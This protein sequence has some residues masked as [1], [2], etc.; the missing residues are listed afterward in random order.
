[1]EQKRITP[2]SPRAALEPEHVPIPKRPSRR[3]RHPLVIIGNAVITLLLLV[4]IVLGGAFALGKQRFEAS[5]P[6][7]QDKIV[8]IPR[9]LGTRDIADL[10]QRE[11]VIDQPW[12]FIG[13]VGLL[14]AR[15][16]E[17]KAGEY[18]FARQASLR[19]VVDTIIEGKV[20]QHL[21]T[22]PE[23]LTSE[24]IVQRLLEV[25]ALSGNIKEIPREG[26][27]LP[28]SYRFTR[29]IPREQLV[30][31]MQEAQRRVLREIW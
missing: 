13:A 11:G 19:D 9:G 26:T 6:L 31:R 24:Q 4:A 16:E 2:R 29:G 1:M 14:K 3:A 28:E 12:V 22:I 20:V 8:N 17:L 27:L 10:L 18:Q 7:A 21:L 23:G 5:G 30:Q 25:E 15:G